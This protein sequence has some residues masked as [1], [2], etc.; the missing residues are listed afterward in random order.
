MPIA[1]T[2]RSQKWT[3][4]DILTFT[5]KMNPLFPFVCISLR[6]SHY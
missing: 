5:L 1:I 2:L 6:Q 3:F 4:D